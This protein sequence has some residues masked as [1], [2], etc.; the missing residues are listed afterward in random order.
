MGYT[1]NLYQKLTLHKNTVQY[2]DL[3]AATHKG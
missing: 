1:C 3:A 2:L